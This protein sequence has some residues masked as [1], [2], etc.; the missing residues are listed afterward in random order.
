M[1]PV[2]LRNLILVEADIPKALI[3]FKVVINLN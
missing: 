2:V 1:A 3:I